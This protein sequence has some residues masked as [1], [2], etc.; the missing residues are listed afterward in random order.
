MIHFIIQA[1][2]TRGNLLF[3]DKPSHSST[4]S[5]SRIWRPSSRCLLAFLV[6][7]YYLDSA[8][9]EIGVR[10]LPNKAVFW[11]KATTKA[12]GAF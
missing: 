2:R 5:F 9:G 4:M 1:R 12:V 8:P 11:P 6:V 7:H 3:A 10:N